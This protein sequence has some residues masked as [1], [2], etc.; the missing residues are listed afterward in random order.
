MRWHRNRVRDLAEVYTHHREVAAMLDLVPDMFPTDDDPD[1]HDRTFL[2]PA[3]RCGTP[4]P[5]AVVLG[6]RRAGCRHRPGP[7]TP[8]RP[9]ARPAGSPVRSSRCTRTASGRWGR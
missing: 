7:E 1:R 9:K 3:T 6:S 5:D 2:E 4:R 8:T